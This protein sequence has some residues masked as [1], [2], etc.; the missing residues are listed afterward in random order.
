MV[1][2]DCPPYVA[3]GVFPGQSLGRFAE[4]AFGAT[5]R[6]YSTQRPPS[7]RVHAIM[8][9]VRHLSHTSRV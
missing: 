9:G 2:R 1:A 3:R 6:A 8:P 7:G 5:T 4:S